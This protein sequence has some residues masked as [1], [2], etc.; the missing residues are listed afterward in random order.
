MIRIALIGVG[1]MGLSHLAI[2]NS[3]PDVGLVA[4]CDS[5]AYVL[6]ALH[7]YTGIKCYSDYRKLLDEEALDAVVIA[8][9]S[10]LH[11]EMVSAALERGLNV[12]CEKPFC[13]DIAE[14]ERLAELA[15]R[16]RLVNQ[17][18]YHHRFVAA[19]QESKRLINAGILGHIHHF[20]A[21]AYG[22]VVLRPT[23]STWRSSKREGGGC[24]YDYA[25]HAI[26]LVNYLVGRPT[27]VGGTALNKVFSLDVEDE[28]YS[29]LFYADGKTGQLAANWSDEGHR[30][31][32]LKMTVWGSNGK[33]TADRQEVQVYLRKAVPG[34]PELAQGWNVIYTT[35]LTRPVWFYLRGEEYSAQID[36]F[37]ECIKQGE[38]ET[39]CTFRSALDADLVAAMIRDDAQA[40]R[41][42][43]PL[44]A[45]R[46]GS[47]YAQ[48]GLL[49]T[50]RSLLR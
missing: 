29:T 8:T 7:K 38:A 45:S 37:I 47:Q 17:V 33:L 44:P 16:K 12:Y 5:A 2:I 49:Q 40:V 4:V 9:P 27:A 32:S 14:G 19:F 10:R 22:P 43:A 6:G 48:G 24:L 31:M 18:G 50:F 26:D 42:E 13:L 41:S 25:C 36:H 46:P 11:G 20:R 39:L 1:K 15:G 35:Q 30:K 23:E 21:E 3:H 28:V 34:A